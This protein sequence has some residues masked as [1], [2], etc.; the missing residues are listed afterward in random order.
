MSVTAAVSRRDLLRGVVSGTGVTATT[1][2]SAGW[3]RTQST[4]TIEMTD[5]L[6]FEPDSVT[7]PPGTTVVWENVGSIGHS[8]T[9]YEGQI[10]ADASYFASGEF[11]TEEDARDA[12]PEG[13][14]PGGESF[15]RTFEV[16]GEYDYFCIPHES[17]GMIASISVAA[18]GSPEQTPESGRI[19]PQ[20][21]DSART[22]TIAVLVAISSVL[23]L[24]YFF[25]KYGG[26]Y[27]TPE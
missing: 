4:R 22:I 24:T 5:G 11:D 13:D 26:D 6:V 2:T 25:M 27:E 3:A 14:V 10:P 1:D 16:E 12:Y 18:G 9:A 20:V 23:A 21:P 7:I 8:I 19:L 17:A 15:S